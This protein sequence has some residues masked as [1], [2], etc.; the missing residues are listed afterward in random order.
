VIIKEG[1]RRG[2]SE[3]P[4]DRMRAER[5]KKREGVILCG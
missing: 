1:K 5:G 2:V 3:N 4:V